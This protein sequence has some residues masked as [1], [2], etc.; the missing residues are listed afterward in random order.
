MQHPHRLPTALLLLGL[1]ACADKSSTTSQTASSSASSAL[2]APPPPPPPPLGCALKYQKRLQ[3]NGFV[4]A[5]SNIAISSSASQHFALIADDEDQALHVVNTDTLQQTG[6]TPLPG[7]PGHLLILASGQLA[8]T[9]RDKNTLLLMEPA[10]DALAKPFEERCSIPMP[11]EP[12][13]IAASKEKLLITSAAGSALSLLK[14]S[15][16]SLEHTLAL[17]RE[18]RAVLIPADEKNAFISHIAGSAVSVIDLNDLSKP[19]EAADLRAGRRLDEKGTPDD[20]RPR[21]VSQGFALAHIV[22]ASPGGGERRTLRIFAPHTSVDPG[23]FERGATVGYGGGG[24]G[25]RPVAPIVSVLDPIAKRSITSHVAGAFNTSDC[26]LP[27]SAVAGEQT[28]FVACLGTDTILELDPWIGDP[29]AAEVRRFAVPAGP[30]GL[31]LSSDGKQLFAYSSF[32]RALST[33]DVASGEVKALALWR[34]AGKERD[35]KIERGR[36]LFHATKDARISLGRACATCHPDGRDDGLL[37]T[38]PDGFRQTPSL[39]GRLKDTAPYSWFGDNPTVADHLE[40]TFERLGGTG[41]HKQPGKADLEA[42][43]AYVQSLPL[44][45]ASAPTDPKA[46]ERGQ[47]AFLSYGCNDCHKNGGGIDGR[48][49]NLGTAAPGDKRQSFDTPSLLRVRATAPYFHDGRYATL[50]ALLSATDTKMIIGVLS[51]T[52]KKDLIAYLETL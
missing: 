7:T 44:P 14:L 39:A 31:A 24:D 32:D 26:L 49:H 37:W 34:R 45:P 50:D 42:L 22:G 18:P 10:D 28:L 36:K 35:P 19:P 17:P 52:D 47:K 4:G 11:A 5:S 6:V 27:R 33:I 15:D 2:A 40:K 29:M 23:A 48:A 3:N 41:L 21:E 13:A 20:K 43:I 1:F 9:L 51:E 25:P 8:I 46:A 30:T 16:F 38:S 12:L